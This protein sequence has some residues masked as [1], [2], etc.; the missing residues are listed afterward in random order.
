MRFSSAI[1]AA[2]IGICATSISAF[3]PSRGSIARSSIASTQQSSP[4]TQLN[5]YASATAGAI[6]LADEYAQRDVYSMEEFASQYGMQKAPGVELYSDD[7]SDYQLITQQPI[8]AGQTILYVPSDI[9]LSSEKAYQEFGGEIQQAE[10][11]LVQIDQGTKARLPLFRLMVKILA[12]YDQGENS[13]WFPWLNSLP[14]VYYNGVSMTNDCFSCLPP[15][16]GWL[17]ST[18]KANYDS[19]VQALRGGYVALQSVN[20]DMVTQWAYNV[21][22]TRFQEVWS[23]TRAKLIAPMA[24]ML[25]HSAEPNCEITFD[26][27]GNCQVLAMY[28]IPA[29]MPLTISYGDPTNPTPIFA[30]FGFL[31]SDCTTLFCKAMHLEPYIKELGIDFKDLLIQVE[32]GEIAPKV[33]DL[34]LYHILATNDPG[35]AEQ[36][37]VAMKSGDEATRQQYQDQYFQYT[38][39]SMKQHVYSILEDVD[40]LTVRAQNF[41]LNTHPRVPVIVAHNNLVRDTFSM[42]AQLLEQMG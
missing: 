37:Y 16:A 10:Q 11:V 24:D 34:F 2:A 8:G 15:Y 6:N 4:L 22:L 12:E 21:A 14:R 13:A 29:G 32:T 42:T 36:Y 20:D 5:Q 31:P 3:T 1:V 33:W 19:F 23:P 41:D 9:I 27:M 7:G 40:T 18:E 17:T 35:A 26:D 30:Q 25:N 28:D 39:D 38:L